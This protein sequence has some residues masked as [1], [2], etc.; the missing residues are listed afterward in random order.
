MDHFASPQGALTMTQFKAS[1]CNK[2]EEMHRC[3][4]EAPTKQVNLMLFAL[5]KTCLRLIRMAA[6]RVG[7]FELF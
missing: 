1:F 2:T 3:E 6:T 4:Q 7:G 5:Y